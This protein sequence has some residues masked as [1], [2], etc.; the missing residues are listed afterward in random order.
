MLRRLAACGL[1]DVQQQ[2]AR[3]V[4][5]P[6]V[7]T[8][9][10]SCGLNSYCVCLLPVLHAAPS[11]CLPAATPCLTPTPQQSCSRAGSASC[12]WRVCCMLA[13]GTSRSCPVGNVQA[14]S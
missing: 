5:H 4:S 7:L 12:S 14:S 1:F 10:V 13:A 3:R 6:S 2:T 8:C 9:C 11:P